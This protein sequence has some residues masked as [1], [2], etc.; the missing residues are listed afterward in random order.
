MPLGFK[1]PNQFPI[2]LLI[3]LYRI[4]ERVPDIADRLPPT[5]PNIAPRWANI[6]AT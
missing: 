2:S 1:V 3:G 6:A 4:P 5:W